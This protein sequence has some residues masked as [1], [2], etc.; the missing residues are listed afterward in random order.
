MF[1]KAFD[2]LNGSSFFLG[3]MMLI[4]NIWSRHIVHEFSDS[5]DEYRENIL[6]RR[7]AVFAVCFVG[8]RNVAESLMLTAAFVVLA[9]GT[10]H[11]KSY[12]ARE[13]M[14]ASATE[15]AVSVVSAVSSAASN[16]DFVYSQ[17]QQ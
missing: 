13:G 16:E 5:D 11:G 9:S 7:L 17:S 8:T 6:I 2:H 1:D 15:R 3:I 14:K 10:Y 4:L 12:F